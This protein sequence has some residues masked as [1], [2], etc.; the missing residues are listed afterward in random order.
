[1][2]FETSE[3]GGLKQLFVLGRGT[4][5]AVGADQHIEILQHRVERAGAVFVY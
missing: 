2:E 1:M 3:P 4:F 5:L